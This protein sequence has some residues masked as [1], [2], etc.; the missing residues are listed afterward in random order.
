MDA[1]KVDRVNRLRWR[2]RRGLKELDIL[3]EE[4]ARTALSELSDEQLDVFATLL[5]LPD[6]DLLTALTATGEH[7]DAA[8]LAVRAVVQRYL[9]GNQLD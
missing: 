1:S 7:A 3:L 8:T 4:F 9:P 6:Q 2:C 5:E